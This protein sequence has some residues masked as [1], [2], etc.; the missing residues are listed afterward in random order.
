MLECWTWVR[1]RW[2][3]LSKLSYV[4]EEFTVDNVLVI[5]LDSWD[6]LADVA[7][8]IIEKLGDTPEV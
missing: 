5:D 3:M 2:L 8:V 7:G 4:G 1:L 6:D